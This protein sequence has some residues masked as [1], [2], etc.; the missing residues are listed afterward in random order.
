MDSINNVR[1][2]ISG[3]EY[4]I[5]GDVDKETTKKVAEY[6]NSKIAEIHSNT[7]SRDNMRLTV[8]S[9]MNIAGELFEVKARHEEDLK[10]LRECEEKVAYLTRK[11]ESIL[12]T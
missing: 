11:I 12:E 10:R 1:V 3:V 7:A 9:A 6:V 8:L 5:I 2:V 4:S